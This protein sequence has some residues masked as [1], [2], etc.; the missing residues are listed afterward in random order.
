[1]AAPLHPLGTADS[2]GGDFGVAWGCWGDDDD[3]SAL[4]YVCGRG[5]DRC[6]KLLLE[7]GADAT[8]GD[9]DG[10][11]AL[12]IAA[13]YLNTAVVR[14]LL[15]AGADPDQK[16]RAGRSVMALLQKLQ[17]PMDPYDPTGRGGWEGDGSVS[18]SPTVDLLIQS[19]LGSMAQR[20]AAAAARRERH[21]YSTQN[22]STSS[23]DAGACRAG[24]RCR[25][26]CPWCRG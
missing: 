19:P 21:L 5:S 20:P 14:T 15:D 17:S 8:A 26:R 24:G 9:K 1:M 4:H 12:H 23:T 18:H 25:R 7:V 10:F 6:A 16:D 3:D 13:G 22:T 11:T 2:R